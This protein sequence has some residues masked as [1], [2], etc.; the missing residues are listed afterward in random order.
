MEKSGKIYYYGDNV[1]TDVIIPA[2]YLNAFDNET[3][4]A[5]CMEDID[6]D[7]AQTVTD[8]DVIIGGFNFGLGSSREH[9]PLA[10]K[11]SGVQAVI[12]KSFARIFYRNCINVGLLAIADETLSN[13][14]STAKRVRIDYDKNEIVN[15]DNGERYQISLPSFVKE[16]LKY[17]GLVNAVK[18]G[19]FNV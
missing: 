2:R 10:I 13:A 5:H 17:G 11:A 9:A 14:L 3:L 18:K 1:N 7:F 12:A 19:G 15:L 4:R 8:G 6:A 16:I